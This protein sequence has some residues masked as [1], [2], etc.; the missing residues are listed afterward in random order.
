M[1]EILIER[2]AE[3]DLKRLSAKDFHLIVPHIKALLLSVGVLHQQRRTFGC[4]SRRPTTSERSFH[5]FNLLGI[6][7]A[8][9]STYLSAMK[10]ATVPSLTA[11]VICRNIFCLTSPAANTPGTEVFGSSPAIT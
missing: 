3:R 1:H 11:V 5:L 8:N 2:T 9:S 6:H 10:A 4:W 7:V